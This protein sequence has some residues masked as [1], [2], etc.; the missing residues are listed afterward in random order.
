LNSEVA[1]IEWAPGKCGVR[2]RSGETERASRVVV[3]V[4][5]GVLQA[6][7]IRFNPEPREIFE[8]VHSLR[9]GQAVRVTIRFERAFWEDDAG[10]IMSD[11]PVFPT[12]WTMLPVRA[13]VLTGWSAGPKA[14]ALLGLPEG[15]V[16]ERALA[17]LRRMVRVEP[18]RVERA[19]FHDWHADRFARGAY[20]WVP[21]GAL[22]ARE[23]LAAPVADTLYFA[24]EA[25]DLMGYG[26]T[27]HGAIASGRRAA[28]QIIEAEV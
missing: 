17:S 7:G 19:W 8:A 11:E 22:S 15:E 23:A 20:S 10:F 1:A 9:F 24:G 12:W 25:I 18:T 2:L 13:P 28:R 3:T 6:R 5:L 4:P 26:G 27:V 16:I 21:A 14:D